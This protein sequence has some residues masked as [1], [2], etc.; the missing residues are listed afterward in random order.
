MW[1]KK[2]EPHVN[3]HM[4]E[5]QDWPMIVHIGMILLFLTTLW[6]GNLQWFYP[7]F[8]IGRLHN[9][10]VFFVNLS[11]TAFHKFHTQ[12]KN[13]LMLGDVPISLNLLYSPLIARHQKCCGSISISDKSYC[14]FPLY[15]RSPIFT[16]HHT[17]IQVSRVER[18]FCLAPTHSAQMN[19]PIDGI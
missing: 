13:T 10:L 16:R 11:L 3:N 14:C 19:L 8:I 7:F 18:W 4:Y 1:R 15:R 12:Y 5:P 17:L 2:Q 9:Q 6:F